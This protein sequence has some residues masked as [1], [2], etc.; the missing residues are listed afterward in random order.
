ML[1]GG[2][3]RRHFSQDHEFHRRKVFRVHRDECKFR[4]NPENYSSDHLPPQLV[5][6][7][8]LS[9]KICI[10]CNSLLARYSAIRKTFVENQRI[11]KRMLYREPTGHESPASSKEEVIHPGGYTVIESIEPFEETH[12]ITDLTDHKEEKFI[13]QETSTKKLKLPKIHKCDECSF[14]VKNHRETLLNH[15]WKVH[16]GQRPERKVLVCELCSK[17]FLKGELLKR[18]LAMH[19][20]LKRFSCG[21][22]S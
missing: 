17:Q 20:N 9:T 10:T 6:S 8:K 14:Q 22:L 2:Y 1:L 15:K 7:D 19:S 5:R 13:N 12:Q 16:G 4:E 11:L 3:K 18:H 21:K